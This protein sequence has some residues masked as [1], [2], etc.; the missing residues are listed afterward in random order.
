[1]SKAIGL[2]LY[3]LILHDALKYI[4]PFNLSEKIKKSLNYYFHPHVI[5]DFKLMIASKP[6]RDL[7]NTEYAMD[8]PH[9][10]KY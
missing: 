7:K 10:A 3:D 1:L 5:W 2:K 4:F 8:K 6:Q 9:P